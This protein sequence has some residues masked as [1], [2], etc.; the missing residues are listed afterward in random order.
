[1]RTQEE[2]LEKVA[3][4]RE[5]FDDF[6]GT[7]RADLIYGLTYENAKPYLTEGATP[8]TFKP[9]LTDEEVIRAVLEYLD[10]AWG[11]ATGHRGLSASRSIDHMRAWMWLLGDQEMLD[12]IESGG[13]YEN[14]GAPILKRIG[15]K[16][17]Y[18]GVLDQFALNMAAGKKCHA[19]CNEGCGR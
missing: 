3:E 19:D 8:E 18:K 6:F 7:I 9:T 10:F 14:Y 16:Y 12:F 13:N 15:D 2:I 17:G 11:K 4:K 1:M 5:P